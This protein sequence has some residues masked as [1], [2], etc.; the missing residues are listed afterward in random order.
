MKSLR[1][2]TGKGICTYR[3][4]ARIERRVDSAADA[5]E[6]AEGMHY[7]ENRAGDEGDFSEERGRIGADTPEYG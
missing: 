1:G 4:P 7:G 2:T 6:S 5:R 3:L